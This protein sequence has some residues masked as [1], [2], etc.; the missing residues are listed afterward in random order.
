LSFQRTQSSLHTWTLSYEGSCLWFPYSNTHKPHSQ[1]HSLITEPLWQSLSSITLHHLASMLWKISASY[2]NMFEYLTTVSL[3][4]TQWSYC[5]SCQ[6][7]S[8][9]S[10]RS[11]HWLESTPF[12]NHTSWPSSSQDLVT[13][14]W[15]G[16]FHSCWFL[17]ILMHKRM[18]LV[19]IHSCCLR[20]CVSNW[21]ERRMHWWFHH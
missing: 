14:I 3:N 16:H 4:H 7:Q 9:T 8:G 10:G 20:S 1:T 5:H 17:L 2:H 11:P 15:K 12:G 18:Y 19:H 13:K 6:P 21:G